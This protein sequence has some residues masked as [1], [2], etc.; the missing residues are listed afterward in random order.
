MVFLPIDFFSTIRAIVTGTSVK[1]SF[2]VRASVKNAVEY[3]IAYHDY[4][5]DCTKKITI[6]KDSDYT[7]SHRKQKYSPKNL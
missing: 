1:K 5:A 6:R 7:D 4:H 3:K 2:T